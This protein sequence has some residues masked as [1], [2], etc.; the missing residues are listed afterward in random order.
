MCMSNMATVTSI[1]QS[2]HLDAEN[3]KNDQ[4]KCL[5]NKVDEFELWQNE[6]EAF[7]VRQKRKHILGWMYTFDIS[8]TFTHF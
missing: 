5:L 1:V 2:H 8:D 4:G 7:K 3:H 6:E